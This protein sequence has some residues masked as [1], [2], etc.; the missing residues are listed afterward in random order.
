MRIL[1]FQ[2]LDVETPG[3]FGE[4]WRD[5]GHE[6][7]VVALDAGE[8]I[9][10]LAPFD[11]MAVMGGPQDVWQEDIYPWLGSE[12]AA[13]RQW[14]RAMARPYFGICLGHQLLG[15]ALGGR[16]GPMAEPEVGLV[17]VTLSPDGET[18]AALAGFPARFDSL[19]WHGAE[20][21]QLPE[22]AAVLAS[23]GGCAV[24]AMRWGRH[25]Y[26]IQYHC[27]ILDQTIADWQRIPAYKAS[28]EHALG[29]AGARDLATQVVPRLPAFR[30]MACQLNDNLMRLIM[31]A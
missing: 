27:E 30:R 8:P 6:V 31:A 16:V 14:V 3:V 25:A 5:A 22:G 18:D 26:G 10:D 2:H 1:V 4:F 13:I 21:T 24:Q 11:M 20:V 7:K 12:K 19:Q 15:A 28:L 23:S 9:P 29:A 17:P